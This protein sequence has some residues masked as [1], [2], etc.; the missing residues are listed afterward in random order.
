MEQDLR[1]YADERFCYLTTVGRVSGQLHEIEMWFALAGTTL[2]MLAGNRYGSDWV[3][4]IQRDPAV[5][6]RIRERIFT[7]HGRIVDEESGEA[8]TARELIG[9]KYGE[10][11]PGEPRVGW[12]WQ[13]LPVAVDLE[14]T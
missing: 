14:I 11:Q 4:N 12:T 7:G 6:V 3:K 10:W 8:V 5:R 2:Y 1:P 13:A 9:P